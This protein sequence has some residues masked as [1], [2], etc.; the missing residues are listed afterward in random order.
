MIPLQHE[1]S[2]KYRALDRATY[3]MIK[4]SRALSHSEKAK[5][6]AECEA[7]TE[8]Y[9]QKTA[10]NSLYIR[11]VSITTNK[12]KKKKKNISRLS[13]KSALPLRNPGVVFREKD[14][15]SFFFSD[16]S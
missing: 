13:W 2:D 4:K 12:K 11:R 16:S 6:D 10:N 3:I 14:R 7:D 1:A 8:L 9:S 15:P 5:E